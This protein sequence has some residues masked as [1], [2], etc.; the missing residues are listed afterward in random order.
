MRAGV[1]DVLGKLV[2]LVIGCK[3]SEAVRGGAF[4]AK[5]RGGHFGAE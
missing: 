3:V 2:Q 4:M 5:V 1:V